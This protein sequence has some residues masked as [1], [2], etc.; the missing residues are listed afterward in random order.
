MEEATSQSINNSAYIDGLFSFLASNLVSKCPNF[1]G[2][3][4]WFATIIGFKKEFIVNIR[5]EYEYIHDI[6][7]FNKKNGMLFDLDHPNL[8]KPKKIEL[9]DD[10]QQED[11]EDDELVDIEYTTLSQNTHPLCESSEIENLSHFSNS[12]NSS[13]SSRSS[14]TNSSYSS[15]SGSGS[16]FNSSD[17]S[18]Y[19]SS[20]SS[21]EA[22]NI[23]I[24]NFP[25][26]AIAM[27]KC[28]GGTLD[29]LIYTMK[30]SEDEWRSVLFQIV[31]I[32]LKY[33]RVFKFTHNDSHS[34]NWMIVN[35]DIDYLLIT[36]DGE[37]YKVPTF[38][39]LIKLIDFGRA[40]FEYEGVRY[41][42]SSFG[43]DGD[44]KGQY[45]TE[46]FYNPLKPRVDPNSS[47]DLTRL[48]CSLYD[49]VYD[50]EECSDNVFEIIDEWCLDDKGRNVLYK[51]SGYDRYPDFK[52]YKMI[53]RTCHNNCPEIQVKNKFF[54]PFITQ[55]KFFNALVV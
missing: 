27:E 35:T 24:F 19:E 21:E 15:G 13:C 28:E 54:K 32:L 52:L 50:D 25:V 11:I 37:N 6:P 12:S 26:N 16:G 43:P 20:N 29:N 30:L 22:L 33:K 48:A 17:Y 9:C 4:E 36:V 23:K 51:R 34:R 46:P 53:S 1:F 10:S 44:A 2:S 31:I 18:D 41:C 49:F 38:G 8:T 14:N 39:R 55:E 45:N 42:S 40:I 47:F 5:D 7:F 3:V